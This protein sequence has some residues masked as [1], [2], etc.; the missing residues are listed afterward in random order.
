MHG[1]KL[2]SNK[3]AGLMIPVVIV[4]NIWESDKVLPMCDESKSFIQIPSACVDLPSQFQAACLASAKPTYRTARM[5]LV[6]SAFKST[7]A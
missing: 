6:N 4:L 3:V 5:A 1:C 2:V 7:Q